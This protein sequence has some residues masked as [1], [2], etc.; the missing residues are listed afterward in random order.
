[1]EAANRGAMEAGGKSIGLNIRL[2][3]EQAPNRYITRDLVFN[4]HYFF[5]RKFWFAYLAK[6]LVVFPGGFGTIDEMFEILTLAQ[7]GKLSKK[8]LVILYGGE[9]L[10]RSPAPGTAG[11]VGGHQRRG[12][13]TALPRRFGPR[14]VRGAEAPS[15]EASHGARD[16]AGNQGARHREDARVK[17]L[18]PRRAS[19]AS[20]AATRGGARLRWS[21]EIAG[22]Q[23]R[24]GLAVAR[25]ECERA[26]AG[27]PTRS[28]S[29]KK[30]GKT[31][32]THR[33]G[34][35]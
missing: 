23:L 29:S 21:P 7:T 18:R 34:R 19:G 20:R 5:M 8:L 15:D 11:G 24:R 2:P 35:S 4:F 3:F 1:M 30:G 22:D 28:K 13:E 33:S 6:A 31:R 26:K 25:L 9:Y 32:W 12:P 17:R 10:E 27:G 16:A 14:S